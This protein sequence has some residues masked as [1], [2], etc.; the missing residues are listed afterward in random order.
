MADKTNHK[1]QG[2]FFVLIQSANYPATD[3]VC[4]QQEAG[5]RE[6]LWAFTRRESALS[7]RVNS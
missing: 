7:Y 5:S 4:K 1:A 6:P 2:S 3:P